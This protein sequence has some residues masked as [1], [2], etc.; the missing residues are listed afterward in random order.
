MT[1]VWKPVVGREG[2]YEVSDHGR[3]RSLAR[4]ISYDRR[5]QYSGRLITVTRHHA[6]KMLRPGPTSTGHLT[7]ALGRG[8]SAL[9]HRLVLQAFVGPCPPKPFE[10]LHWDD[11]RTNNHLTNLRWGSRSANLHD[12]VRNGRKAV[13]EQHYGAKLKDADIPVIRSLIGRRSYAQIG[14][15]Y[16][17]SEASIRQIRDRKAWRHIA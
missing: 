7:V 11:V 13:G 12:A 3:V 2:E 10:G 1:E 5:D 9:V 8:G 16:G 6:A 17:V 4:T 15:D 14:R